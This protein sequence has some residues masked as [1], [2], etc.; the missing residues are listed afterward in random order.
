MFTK[1]G[2]LQVNKDYL[3][4]FLG[5]RRDEGLDFCCIPIPLHSADH[6]LE[7]RPIKPENDINGLQHGPA[8]PTRHVS[9]PCLSNILLLS[10]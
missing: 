7:K 4:L 5:R 8:K 1:K 3:S 9:F 2:L 10:L 6:S